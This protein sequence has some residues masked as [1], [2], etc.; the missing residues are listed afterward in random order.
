M[1]PLVCS[2]SR[3]F[4]LALAGPVWAGSAAQGIKNFDQVDQHVYRGDQPSDAGFRYLAQIGVKTVIDLR[5]ADAR[6]NKE[7]RV[8]TAARDAVR[9]RSNDRFDASYRSRNRSDSRTP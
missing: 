9:Q 3:I 7:E 6:S 2:R 4:L 1:S 5:E 8:V